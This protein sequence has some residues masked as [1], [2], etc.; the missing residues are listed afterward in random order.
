VPFAR[1]EGEG[2]TEL[3]LGC[4]PIRGSERG[5]GEMDSAGELS[6]LLGTERLETCC[7]AEPALRRWT[8]S[9][10]SLTSFGGTVEESVAFR[11]LGFT[12]GDWR[13]RVDGPDR[14]AEALLFVLD[15][16]A[17]SIRGAA[18]P[19]SIS[20]SWSSSGAVP[21]ELVDPPAEE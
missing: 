16:G 1:I 5:S 21:S 15:R 20:T 13:M 6:M 10:R 18:E 11:L 12:M 9:R 3:G 8:S 4:G 2:W 14:T 7:C 19:P 17:G